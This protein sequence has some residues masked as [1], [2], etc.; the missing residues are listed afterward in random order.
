MWAEITVQALAHTA[1]AVDYITQRPFDL[2][3]H[4]VTKAATSGDLIFVCHFGGSKYVMS[5]VTLDYRAS[6][7]SGS[8]GKCSALLGVNCYVSNVRLRSIRTE[9]FLQIDGESPCGESA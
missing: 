9:P 1:V 2:I 3:P 7:T 5:N 4:R 8:G 6:D